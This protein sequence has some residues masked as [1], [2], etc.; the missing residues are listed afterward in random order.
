MQLFKSFEVVEIKDGTIY[1]NPSYVRFVK[2]LLSINKGLTEEQLRKLIDADEELGRLAEDA[3]FK[4]ERKRLL[5]LGRIPEMD[6]VR[7]V[8][9]L[10]ASAGYDIESFNGDIPS[11]TNDRFIEVKASKQNKIRFYW[12]LNEYEKAKELGDKYWIYFLGD[13]KKNKTDIVPVMIRNPA[14]RIPELK[15]LNIYVV[16]Y[17]VEA[18]NDLT[19][20]PILFNEVEGLLL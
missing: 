3:V 7:R 4:Y 17:I 20:T 12:S 11:F 13:F 10:N 19:L 15:N 14:K 2:D 18:I 16:K 1:V 6:L 5:S 9:P 8:S